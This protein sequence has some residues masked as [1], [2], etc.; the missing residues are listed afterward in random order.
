MFT[1]LKKCYKD[2]DQYI[3]DAKQK[4]IEDNNVMILSRKDIDFAFEYFNKKG[5]KLEDYRRYE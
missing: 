4:C 2:Q 5:Y 3:L 1:K